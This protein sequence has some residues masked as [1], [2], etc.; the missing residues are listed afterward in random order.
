MKIGYTLDLQFLDPQLR[1]VGSG[2]P[3]L[4]PHLRP[5][6]AVGRDDA[7]SPTGRGRVVDDLRRQPDLRLHAPPGRE[8]P[9]RQGRHRR[10]RRLQLPTRHR[11]RRQGTRQGRVARRRLVHRDR[12]A[13]VHGQ[14]EADRA[15]SSCPAAVIGHCRSSTKTPSTTSPRRR[16]APGPSPS[17]SGSRAS[18][19]ATRRIPPT[20]TPKVLA[21]WPDEIVSQPIAEA[22]TRIANLKAGQIDLAENVPSQ[23]VKELEQDPSVQLFRQPFTASYWCV[24]F[25]LRQPPFDNLQVRQAVA[26]RHRQGGDSPERLLRHR[27]GRLQ[28]DPLRPLGL[29]SEHHLPG[30]R[31]RGGQGADGRGGRRRWA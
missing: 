10:R 7:R 22:L 11:H 16:T 31:R 21:G 18:T 27:R 19:S 24:N 20:G 13:R 15:P 2:S 9:L 6:G 14:A 23:L 17:S 4:H 3:A 29:R 1:P 12:P 5:A 30:A 28:P 8:V 26:M 25:N